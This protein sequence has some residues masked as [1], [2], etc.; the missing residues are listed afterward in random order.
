[1]DAR[2]VH[3]QSLYH[4]VFTGLAELGCKPVCCYGRPV[5]GVEDASAIQLSHA[6]QQ[7]CLHNLLSLDLRTRLGVSP[8]HGVEKQSTNP[9]TRLLLFPDYTRLQR[10]GKYHQFSVADDIHGHILVLHL[11][12]RH[13]APREGF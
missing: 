3:V 5:F 10:D 12:D 11:H 9:T 13:T 7:S 4:Y 1:V 8:C 2:R 6:A